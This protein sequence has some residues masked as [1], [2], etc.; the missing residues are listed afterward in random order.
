ML[1]FLLHLSVTCP[2]SVE[3]LEELRAARPSSALTFALI[4]AKRNHAIKDSSKTKNEELVKESDDFN[5]ND[6]ESIQKKTKDN[7]GNECNDEIVNRT[8]KK[9]C[10]KGSLNEETEDDLTEEEYRECV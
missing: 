2:C 8:E 5:S 9:K 1:Y 3:I 6:D 10:M 4:L 7:E